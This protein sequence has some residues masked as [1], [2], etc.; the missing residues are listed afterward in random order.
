[1][2]ATVDLIRLLFLFLFCSL[3]GKKDAASALSVWR[4][5]LS[6][7]LFLLSFRIVKLVLNC[8]S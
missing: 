5:L 8:L 7:Q 3:G 1:M 2:T 4:R 6:S